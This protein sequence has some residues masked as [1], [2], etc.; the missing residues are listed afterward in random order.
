MSQPSRPPCLI[1]LYYSRCGCT[2]FW[3]FLSY[4]CNNVKATFVEWFTLVDLE[5]Y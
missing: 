3:T 4:N 2:F 1:V 5:L